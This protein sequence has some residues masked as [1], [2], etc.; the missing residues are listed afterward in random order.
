MPGPEF[1]VVDIKN[2]KA[3]YTT[4]CVRPENPK[5]TKTEASVSHVLHELGN[6]HELMKKR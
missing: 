1:N 2:Q 5:D 6:D 3:H 4:C